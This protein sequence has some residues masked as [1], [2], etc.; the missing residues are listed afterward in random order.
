MGHLFLKPL[1]DNFNLNGG[2]LLSS[3]SLPM[4]HHGPVT[5]GSTNF[6]HSSNS[7][8]SLKLDPK[9][10][11]PCRLSL[12]GHPFQTTWLT[13]ISNIVKV[14]RLLGKVTCSKLSLKFIFFSH[15]PFSG[16]KGVVLACTT[17]QM[18]DGGLIRVR[19]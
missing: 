4:M 7:V 3:W 6:D 19:S 1:R 15:T 5:V 12:Q 17:T 14:C 13:L 11:F 9:V 2:N 16:C 8:R 10:K 18:V